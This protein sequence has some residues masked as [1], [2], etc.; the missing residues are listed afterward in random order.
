[1]LKLL[2]TVL[3]NAS[4]SSPSEEGVVMSVPSKTRVRPNRAASPNKLRMPAEESVVRLAAA[5]DFYLGAILTQL[6]V[7]TDVWATCTQHSTASRL[8]AIPRQP[9][10]PP[11][12]ERPVLKLL[13]TCVL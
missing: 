8:G 9:H 10:V 3:V 1:M 4:P 2:G 13:G 6:C 7:P 11:M 5:K 12:G